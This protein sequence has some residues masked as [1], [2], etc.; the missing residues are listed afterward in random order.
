M[1]W[2]WTMRSLKYGEEE[3]GNIMRDWEILYVFCLSFFFR[4]A[5]LKVSNSKKSGAGNIRELLLLNHR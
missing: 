1:C 3:V 2:V 4:V 5:R